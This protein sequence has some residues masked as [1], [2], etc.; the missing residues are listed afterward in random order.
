MNAVAIGSLSGQTYQGSASVAIGYQAGSIT[1][2]TQAIS[3]GYQAGQ[4]CQGSAS[5]AVGYQAGQLSQ[6]NG[7]LAIGNK[8]GS[9][10]QGTASIAIGYQAGSNY[11]GYNSISLGFQAGQNTQSSGTI[12]IGCQAGNTIQA[13]NTIAIGYQAGYSNQ[14]SGAIA[15]GYQAGQTDQGTNSI[16]IGNL[17]SN[18]RQNTIV[19]NASSTLVTSTTDNSLYVSPIRQNAGSG[20]LLSYNSTT[21]EIWVNTSKSFIINHPLDDKKYLVHACLEGPEQGVYYRGEGQIEN[22]TYTTITL[23]NYVNNLASDFSVQI[24]PIYNGNIT[25]Y[26]ASEVI[27]NTFNVYG[28]N[29]KFYWVVHGSRGNINVEPNKDDVSVKGSGPYLWL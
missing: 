26:S 12:S 24:T 20:T 4:N 14:Q 16:S 8:S 27:N 29:G 6:G 13:S 18:V 17:I 28:K 15:I 5:I 25:S 22:N 11:Q 2:G 9:N 3:I 19:I 10:Y 7:S 21:S 23:P 1:Q